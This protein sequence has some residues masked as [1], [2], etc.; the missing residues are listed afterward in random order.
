MPPVWG[1]LRR[2]ISPE[3]DALT[4]DADGWLRGPAVRRVPSHRSWTSGRRPTPAHAPTALL[5]HY[6]ATN[7]GTAERMAKNRVPR[8]KPNDR[9]ASW[10]V[11][12]AADGVLWQQVSFL[13][14]AW[15]CGK[16][17]IGDYRV[18]ECAV[19]IEL[20]GHGDAFPEEQVGAA[21]LLVR[22]LAGVYGL[23]R[24]DC[25]HGHR[26]YDP[27]RRADPG[28]V[29]AGGVLPDLLEVVFG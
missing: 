16:G 29:W 20:E 27:A 26:D 24:E 8:R 13:E 21:T 9:P 4:I 3:P 12:V 2:L 28:P 11:T 19:G 7:H 10:H 14:V 22:R 17:R 23:D 1:G 5:W 6:T 25:A 15:H 18:N